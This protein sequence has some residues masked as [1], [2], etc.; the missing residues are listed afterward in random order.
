MPGEISLSPSEQDVLFYSVLTSGVT[1]QIGPNRTSANITVKASTN[2]SELIDNGWYDAGP[3]PW[4]FSPGTYLTE[5]YWLPTYLGEPSVINISGSIPPFVNDIAGI[6]Q[7]FTLPPYPISSGVVR[8]QVMVDTPTTVFLGSFSSGYYIFDSAFNVVDSQNSTIFIGAGNSGWV[9]LVFTPDLSVLTPGETYYFYV[10]AIIDWVLSFSAASI[11]F[12]FNYSLFDITPANPSFVGTILYINST[13]TFYNGSLRVTGLDSIGNANA[14]I[15]LRNH[16]N[17]V[18]SSPITVVNSILT[19]PSTNE[20]IFGPV[21]PGYYSLDIYVETWMTPGS[22]LNLT[23]TFRFRLYSGVYVE[24]PIN[25]HIVDP[26]ERDVSQP[27][28]Y[29]KPLPLLYG[30]SSNEIFRRRG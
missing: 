17:T 3:N 18:W 25:L 23:M 6:Y 13:N 22:S 12:Y 2:P 4:L 16:T 11:H 15:Y 5:A 24:Y 21:S 30:F 7:T 20:I 28:V 27:I 10:A 1:D 29:S 26:D 9:N 19:T 8:I 14:S